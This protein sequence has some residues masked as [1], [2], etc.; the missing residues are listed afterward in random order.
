MERL[1]AI[2]SD[3][4]QSFLSPLEGEDLYKDSRFLSPCTPEIIGNPI[5][6]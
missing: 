5:F 3:Y 4:W 2:D 6:R 1:I